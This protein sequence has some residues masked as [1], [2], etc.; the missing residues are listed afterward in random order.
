MDPH[1]G[2]FIID[3]P[4]GKPDHVT[5]RTEEWEAIYY[6]HNKMV[7]LIRLQNAAIASLN[8]DI[9]PARRM[10]QEIDALRKELGIP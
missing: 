4:E 5:L 8:A 2:E 6:W 10:R 9:T 1:T 3:W 7:R